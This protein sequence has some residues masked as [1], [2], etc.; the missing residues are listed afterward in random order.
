M[1][2][3]FCDFALSKLAAERGFDWPCVAV[4]L[5]QKEPEGCDLIVTCD[6]TPWERSDF[7]PDDV[8]C[9]TPAQLVEWLW[10]KHRIL[11]LPVVFSDQTIA[12]SV[13]D[14]FGRG[15]NAWDSFPTIPDA[16]TAA[17]QLIPLTT[18]TPAE[19]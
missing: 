6:A 5:G 13:D 1:T 18:P 3:I 16:L 9:P 12:Y 11:I 2:T 10:E 15:S 14:A 17:L 7:K 19:A 8:F 4:Y